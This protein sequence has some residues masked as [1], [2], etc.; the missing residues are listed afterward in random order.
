MLV[1]VCDFIFL[2]VFLRIGG[3]GKCLERCCCCRR[4]PMM[5]GKSIGIGA[6]VCVLLCLVL[7][8]CDDRCS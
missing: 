6:F 7:G 8:I 2:W 3:D 4:L 5:P 1:L